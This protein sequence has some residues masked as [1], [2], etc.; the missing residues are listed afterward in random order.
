MKKQPEPKKKD[1]PRNPNAIQSKIKALALKRG[2]GSTFCP[3][4]A[5]RALEEDER[6]WRR[7]MPL[8]RREAVKMAQNGEIVITRKGKIQDPFDDIRGVI[9][10]GLPP[11]N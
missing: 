11:E 1:N 2:V 7:L 5:A 8:V 9:R 3:S 10:L 4:E 6:I